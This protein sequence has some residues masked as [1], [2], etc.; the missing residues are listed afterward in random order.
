MDKQAKMVLGPK[1]TKA[2]VNCR[3]LKMKCEVS[4]PPPCRR[5]R[6]TQTACIFKPRANASAIHEFIDEAQSELLAPRSSMHDQQAILDRLDRIEAALGIT[7]EAPEEGNDS[8]D[9]SIDEDSDSV[10]LQGVWNA[11]A[12]LRS[13]TR[14]A[15]DENIWSRPTIKRLWSS[16][17][18]NLPLL[19]FLS[20]REAFASPT[21][22]L[23]ASVLY[24]SALHHR[25]SELASFDAGYFTATCC[26][27]NELLT[28]TLRPGSSTRR[29]SRMTDTSDYLPPK[30]KAFNNILG[31]IM[32]SLSSEA[33][34]DATGSWIAMAYRLW[35]D[36]CPSQLDSTTPEWRGLFSGLQVID[37][38]HASMHMSY[39]ML[40]RQPPTPGIQRVDNHQ[41]NAYQGLSDM[42]HHGLS[43]FVGRG[44]PTIWSSINNS[45]PD[46]PPAVETSFT[47]QDSEVIRLWA[48]K[49]DD[50]L[51]R[52]N[53]ASQPSPSDRQGIVI[54]LQYHLHKLY[55]LSIYHP[56]RG[57]NLSSAKI[58]PVERH[59]LLVSARAVLRLRQDDA[60]IWSNWDL[61]MITWAAILLLRG[62]EDG[63]THQDDLHLI[64]GHL[65]SL[66]RSNQSSE[67]IHTILSERLESSMQAMHTPPDTTS[68]VNV[69]VPTA[70]DSWTIFD[71]EI[72]SLANPPWLFQ[73]SS[74]TSTPKPPNQVQQMQPGL[75]SVH[76]GSGILGTPSH[77][78][79]AG[80]QWGTPEG[81][82]DALPSTL[83]RIFGNE[84]QG[85][86]NGLI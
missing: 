51:V 61:I 42:M 41:G 31:L 52:Y 34:I 72:M 50:W 7:Q 12:H 36:H 35:L 83:N 65:R 63:M 23:L 13:I 40:P 74:F 64:Q 45:V 53:G 3:R 44:L 73:D 67:S 32:A 4:G 66:E 17:L 22:L 85:Q 8:R 47:E 2:C 57:F 21:P 6:H 29:D 80:A 28:P 49:L 20:D 71:Q 62:V 77:Q 78:F 26:A 39:P 19:H 84:N 24:I 38:E 9:M 30:R 76:Y 69:P 70:D 79:A 33:Y 54:L 86:D 68:A 25:S 48:R 5:C 60:S 16:F 14:P 46:S 27:I 75:Q 11:V 81:I 1:P 56:A 18:N 55:V 82:Q 37:I 43:H 59:E 15:P 10:P 58:T